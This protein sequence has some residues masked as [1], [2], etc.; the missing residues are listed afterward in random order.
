M[1]P[2]LAGVLAG[3]IV[4]GI[5]AVLLYVRR[6]AFVPL[7]KSGDSELSRM[8]DRRLIKVLAAIM[9]PAGCLFGLLPGFVYKLMLDRLAESAQFYYLS[10]ALVLAALATVAAIITKKEGMVAEKI[11]LNFIIA[12]G[13]GILIPLFVG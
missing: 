6:E 11:A 5:C 7:L 10:F 1:A 4:G 12:L 3:L 13:F 9:P 8:S 2:L